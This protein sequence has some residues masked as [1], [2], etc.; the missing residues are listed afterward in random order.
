MTDLLNK[1]G[2]FS[3]KHKRVASIRKQITKVAPDGARILFRYC[4]LRGKIYRDISSNIL[5]S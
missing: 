3:N 4:Q 5:D 1:G 2:L